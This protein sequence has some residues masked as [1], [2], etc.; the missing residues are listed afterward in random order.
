M[1]K[2]LKL[3]IKFEK[4]IA[5]LKIIG[6]TVFVGFLFFGGGGGVAVVVAVVFYF[7]EGLFFSFF[8]L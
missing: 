7:G 2:V 5:I 4:F 1:K 3:F 6:I 8:L